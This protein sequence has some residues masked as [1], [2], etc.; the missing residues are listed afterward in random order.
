MAPAMLLLHCP[1]SKPGT[2]S[3]AAN[4]EDGSE[5]GPEQLGVGWNRS[6]CSI[7][8]VYE[9]LAIGKA[10]WRPV[11]SLVARCYGTGMS[12]AAEPTLDHG[13]PERR[14]DAIA[15]ELPPELREQFLAE[16]RA[17]LEVARD[18]LRLDQLDQVIETWWRTAWARRSPR[19]EAAVRR[20]G[21]GGEPFTPEQFA[22]EFLG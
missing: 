4:G 20:A 8:G 9:G 19:Y 17:A 3:R 14:P 18:T 1:T 12:A 13:R 5:R 10:A 6:A 15:A 22:R 11:A 2:S 21:Q 16:Y 7:R